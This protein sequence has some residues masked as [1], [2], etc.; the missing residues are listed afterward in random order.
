MSSYICLPCKV[1]N[2]NLI[3]VGKNCRIRKCGVMEAI[4]KNGAQNFHPTIILGDDVSVGRYCQIYCVD[5]V[6]IGDGCVLRE[7]VY[8]SDSAHGFDP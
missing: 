7:Y 3:Q 2:K 6:R 1:I 8:L 5:S 4:T